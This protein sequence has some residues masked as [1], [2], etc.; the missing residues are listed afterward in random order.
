MSAWVVV[1]RNV[2]T[3]ELEVF[4]STAANGGLAINEAVVLAADGGPTPVPRAS[5]AVLSHVI[6]DLVAARL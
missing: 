1:F 5:K 4:K 2:S 3:G 6:W